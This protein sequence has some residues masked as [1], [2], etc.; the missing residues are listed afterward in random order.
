MVSVTLSLGIATSDMAAEIPEL[1]SAADAALY[2]AKHHGR[3][4]VELATVEDVPDRTP[5]KGVVG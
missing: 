1:L 2:R 3:N 4:C 5:V